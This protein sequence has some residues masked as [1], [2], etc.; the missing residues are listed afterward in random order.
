VAGVTG[1]GEIDLRLLLAN[2]YPTPCTGLECPSSSSGAVI[3]RTPNQKINEITILSVLMTRPRPEFACRLTQ[4]RQKRVRSTKGMVILEFR[5]FW[6]RGNT[7]APQG[8]GAI[9]FGSWWEEGSVSERAFVAFIDDDQAVCDAMLGLLRVSGYKV[10]GFS[11]AEDFLK[12]G[13]LD[14]TSCLITD[15]Q[16]T[17]MSGLALQSRLTELNCRIPVIV[18]TAFPDKRIRDQA[19]SSGAV[20]FLSKPVAK[21]DLLNCI[22][23]ALA[24]GSSPELP[25]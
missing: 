24:D 25:A 23:C 10:E 7:I 6:P 20:C 19:L 15:V 14:T 2:P 18:I 13:R 1:Q 22:R 3:D 9:N 11:S 21:A 5:L 17:G 16:L 8:H 12:S 4:S